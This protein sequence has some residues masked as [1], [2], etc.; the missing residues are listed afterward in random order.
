VGKRFVDSEM[1]LMAHEC[2]IERMN[3]EEADTKEQI[4]LRKQA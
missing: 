4:V 1:R 2:L 3:E